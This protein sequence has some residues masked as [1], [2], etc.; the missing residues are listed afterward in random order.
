[1]AEKYSITTWMPTYKEVR[2]VLRVLEGERYS[3]WLSLKQAISVVIRKSENKGKFVDPNR[4]IP[5]LLPAVDQDLAIRFWREAHVKPHMAWDSVS[6]ARLHQLANFTEERITLTEAGKL[7][8]QSDDSTIAKI[9]Q[10]EGILS[11]LRDVALRGPG[12]EGLFLESHREF[13]RRNTTFSPKNSGFKVWRTRAKNLL[14][15]GLVEKHGKIYQ[16]TEAGIEYIERQQFENELLTS[17]QV[18]KPHSGRSKQLQIESESQLSKLIRD[19]N[20]TV[21]QQLRECLRSI[22]P[23]QFEHLVK[24]LLEAMDYENVEVTGGSHDMGVDVVG[25]IEL[26]IS[27]VRE[28]IQVKRQQ[29]NVGRRVLDSLRGSLHRFDAVRATIV[30]TSGFSTGAKEAAFEKGVAPITLIDGERLIDLMVEH[31]I[32]IRRREIRILEFDPDSLA[33]FELEDS[34]TPQ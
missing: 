10:C 13:L 14:Q 12:G 19:K 6:F 32:G 7:F 3:S 23:F 18:D 2:K 34:E 31:N 33:Q 4:Y 28:V 24:F 22:D 20:Q 5:E 15:R 25:E 16:V 9:D 8:L 30:T 26:G 21:R 29:S 11:I 1:M 17:T 27:H